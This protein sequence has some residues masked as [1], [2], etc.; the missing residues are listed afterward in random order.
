VTIRVRSEAG[1]RKPPRKEP[2]G[3]RVDGCRLW[4]F[5]GPAA[6]DGDAFAGVVGG[7]GDRGSEF[8]AAGAV[9]WAILAWSTMQQVPGRHRGDS[10]T[11]PKARLRGRPGRG[12]AVT[13]VMASPRPRTRSSNPVPSSEESVANLFQAFGVGGGTGGAAGDALSAWSRSIICSFA[14]F[15]HRRGCQMHLGSAHR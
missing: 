6:W 13:D 15:A 8:V 14:S 3:R 7:S 5:D 9:G 11:T 12:E 10:K 1:V 2:A 4:G